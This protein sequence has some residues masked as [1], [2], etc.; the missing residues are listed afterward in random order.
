MKRIIVHWTAGTYIA[1]A[2]DKKHYHFAIDGHGNII[3]G[4]YKPEDNT[5]CSDGHYAAHTGGGNTDSI[6]VAICG[7][8]NYHSP[9]N[10]GPF[11][12][13]KLQ[14]ERMFELCAKLSK[15]YNIPLQNI[16]T[17]YEFGK[18][19]PTTTSAGKIDITYLPPYPNVRA[20]D[21]G[22]FIRTKV[23]WYKLKI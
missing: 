18:A 10:V 8:L 9:T 7:M 17:H 11:P 23:Q 12:I 16:I 4:D 6:G 21:V 3:H 2:T 1:N 22:A 15:Q 13:T 19:H 5:N 14:C 20:S